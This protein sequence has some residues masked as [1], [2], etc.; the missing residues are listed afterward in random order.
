MNTRSEIIRSG[1]T[2]NEVTAS[3]AN[4]TILCSGYFETPATVSLHV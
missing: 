3:N 1:T 4:A 2:E